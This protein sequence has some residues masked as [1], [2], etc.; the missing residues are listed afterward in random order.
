MSRY[1]AYALFTYLFITNHY[2]FYSSTRKSCATCIL[3][4]YN[5]ILHSEKKNCIYSLSQNVKYL[6]T[7]FIQLKYVAY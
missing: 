3:L 6:N 1:F 7:I 2:H 5:N 4:A